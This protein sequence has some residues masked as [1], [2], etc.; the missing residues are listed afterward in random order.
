MISTLTDVSR[1]TARFLFHLAGE[2][3]DSP[4]FESPAWICR[5]GPVPGMYG[6]QVLERQ[7]LLFC[8]VI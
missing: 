6:R 4:L 8:L 3:F 7:N 5:A 2:T 1:K